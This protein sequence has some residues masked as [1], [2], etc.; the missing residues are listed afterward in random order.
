VSWTS[1][2]PD[3]VPIQNLSAQLFACGDALIVRT[4]NGVWAL[5]GGAAAQPR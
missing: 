1:H 2:G 4:G 5:P 3:P